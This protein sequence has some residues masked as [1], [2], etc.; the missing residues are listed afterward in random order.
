MT[1]EQTV[2]E[3]LAGILSNL[4]AARESLAPFARWPGEPLVV[5]AQAA[6]DALRARDAHIDALNLAAGYYRRELKA[7]MDHCGDDNCELAT[8]KIR[9]HAEE[10]IRAA[11]GALA[12]VGVE[13]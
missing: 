4:A 9:V 10:A 3:R 1:S 13:S 8:I 6:A 5:T 11:D 2:E 12:V 7:I